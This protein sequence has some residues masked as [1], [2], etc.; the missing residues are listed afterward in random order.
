MSI[1]DQEWSNRMRTFIFALAA[2]VAAL[3]IDRARATDEPPA[4]D[5]TKNCNTETAGAA[6]GGPEACIRDETVAKDQ[7]AKSWSSYGASGKKD[8]V[9]ES[10]IGG[11][12]SYVELLTCLEMSSGQLAPSGD[13]KR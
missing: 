5:I 13:Q 6:I 8:C 3:A 9:S 11:E 12:K 7:L 1:L 10:S 2:V 4:Y